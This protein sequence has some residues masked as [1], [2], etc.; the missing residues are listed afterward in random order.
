MEMQQIVDDL[1]HQQYRD[2]TKRNYYAVW[3][4]FNQFFIRLDYKPSNW[5][6]R[7]TLFVGFLIQSNKQSSTVKSYIS[8]IKAVLKENNFKID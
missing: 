1:R 4:V 7:L 6:D 8:A 3:R 2:C 5:E